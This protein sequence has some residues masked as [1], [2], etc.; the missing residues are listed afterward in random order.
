[1]KDRKSGSKESYNKPK[2][3]LVSVIARP[4]LLILQE[5]YWKSLM[6]SY[7]KYFHPCR[8]LFNLVNF[9]PKTASESLLSAIY[10]AGFVIQPNPPD[11]I[12]SYM[13]NYATCNIKKILFK[14]SLSNAQ[15]LGIYSY[16]FYLSGN[17]SVSRACLSHFGRMCHALGIGINRIKLP[18]PDQNDRE[19]AYNNIKLYYKWEKLGIPPYSLVSQ[20][21]EFD[22]NIYESAYQLP[23]SSLNLYSNNYENIAYSIFCCQFAKLSNLCVIINTKC[24]KYDFLQAKIILD[25]LNI[26]A[27]KIYNNAKLS[28][29]YINLISDHKI[30][31][32]VYSHLLKCSYII[33]ILCIY[34]K[35][36]EISNNGNLTIVQAILDTGVELWE[37]ISSNT[38]LI[39]VWS[40]GPY[41]ISFHLIQVYPLCTSNLQ[42]VVLHVLKSII[43]LYYKEGFNYNSMNFLIL[44]TQFKLIN[45]K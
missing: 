24:R 28:L 4:L 5:S 38:Y 23:N 35:I 11:E 6:E 34:G 42:K 32:V 17:S 44:Q 8:P 7:F 27:S 36:L 12:C 30:N 40:W 18:I 31:I 14:V 2:S 26:E 1:M 45:S 25:E 33:C 20:D 43:N 37:L 39:N 16:A 9:N 29:E 10:F 21:D 41:I 3:K 19:L 15:A 22:L 13:K